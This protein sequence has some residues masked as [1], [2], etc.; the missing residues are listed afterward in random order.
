NTNY[1]ADLTFIHATVTTNGTTVTEA[2]VASYTTFT[3][4]TASSSAAAPVFTNAAWSGGTFGFN[5]LTSPSQMVTVIYNTNPG[6]PYS[7]WPILLT[8]NSPGSIFHVSD[9]H[10]ATNKTLLYR[11]RNGS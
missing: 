1:T 9:S 6:G 5:I 10:S 11:A 2:F 8:T 7:S 4:S 3:I